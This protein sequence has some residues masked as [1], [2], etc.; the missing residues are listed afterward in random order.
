MFFFS[1]FFF[2]ID[3][4]YLTDS[5]VKIRGWVY[6]IT[7]P[8]HVRS[9]PH[10]SAEKL[11]GTLSFIETHNYKE[12]NM[13]RTIRGAFEEKSVKICWLP[14]WKRLQNCKA[15]EDLILCS[16]HHWGDVFG[17]MVYWAVWNTL[18]VIPSGLNGF[19]TN[20]SVQDWV[21]MACRHC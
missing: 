4:A 3:T 15:V 1:L 8:T 19:Y 9:S 6:K 5:S 11:E 18:S 14:D 21:F 20:D 12:T 13:C 7:S 16:P 17:T 10:I 2:L